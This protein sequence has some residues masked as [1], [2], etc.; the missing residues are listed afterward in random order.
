[1]NTPDA[2]IRFH[3]A[4]D[5]TPAS[6]HRVAAQC[7]SG[8]DTNVEPRSVRVDP[9][10]LGACPH[11]SMPAICPGARRPPPPRRCRHRRRPRPP[12]RPR[13]AERR[14]Q[15]DAAARPRRA[16]A[17]D[18]GTVGLA[19]P[20]QRRLP[21]AGA[22]APRR[23]RRRATSRV[24]P[25]SPTP[26]ADA[27]PGD[28]DLAAGV[29]RR[30]RSYSDALERWLALGAADFDARVGDV[31]ADLGLRRA[32]ARTSGCRRCRVARRRAP[33][34]AALLLARFDVFLLDEPTNDLDLDGL[35]RLE[36]FVIGLGAGVRARQPRPHV[37]RS[38]RSPTSSS[39]TSSPIRSPA[40]A[41]GWEAYLRERDVARQ[42]ARRGVRGRTTPSARRSPD[43][44]SASGS[45]RRRDCRGRRRSRTTTTRT[46]SATS[47]STRPSSWPA[48]R[49]ARRR[50]WSGSTWS[51]SP[52]R[53]GSCGSRSPPAPRSG[54]VVARLDARGGGRSGSF[55]LGPV[56]LQIGYGERVVIDGPNG[57]GKSTLLR[58]LL[59]ETPLTSRASTGVARAWS[60]ADWSRS[61]TSWPT[62]RPCSQAFMGATGM[63]VPEARTL[64]AKFGIG[65]EHVNRAAESLSPG[66]RTRLVL[67]LLMAK[68]SQLPGARRTDQPSRPAG[69]RAA[70]AGAGHVRR[71][72]AAGQPRP[73]AAVQR[74]PHAHHRGP[75]TAA[76]PATPP[77][78]PSRGT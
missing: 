49:R 5:R 11:H 61:A 3:P 7:R 15:V 63:L 37:P 78:D 50:R 34:L 64:L 18:R 39:S 65:A 60:S 77:S 17:P 29:R 74:G 28:A 10:R 8:D 21:A 76:S 58:A 54:D 42:H 20:G 57:A 33:G 9:G 52:A 38:G 2:P 68:G 48:R 14:R 75:S 27:R 70:R 72:R 22:R 45:G 46:S 51:R 56:D 66:E 24:A 67:A 19:P 43:G 55:T 59:G 35:A 25:A 71:H 36:R 62:R 16:L 69:H 30:R 32:P 31:W 41:G 13:R 40:Y 26:S 4:A 23:D 73:V 12:H 47:R 44:R 6:S 1:M 53:R